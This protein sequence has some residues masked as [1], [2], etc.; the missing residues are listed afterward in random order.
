MTSEAEMLQLFMRTL[1]KVQTAF[2]QTIQ[3]RLKEQNVDL[4][5]EMLQIIVCLWKKQGVNQ[6]ELANQ[7]VK[8]KASLTCLINNLEKRNLVFRKEDTNDRRNKLIYLTPEAESIRLSVL[9]LV[10]EIYNMV[11]EKIDPQHLQSS[12]GFLHELNGLF[13]EA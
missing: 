7:T 13:K 9:P 4:T 12:L 10:R 8:D 5:F 11:A 1:S 3:Y 2:R 6:Q